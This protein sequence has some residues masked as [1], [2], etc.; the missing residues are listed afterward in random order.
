MNETNNEV[1]KSVRK[2]M[3]GEKMAS[4]DAVNN[5]EV[6]LGA[7]YVCTMNSY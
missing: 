5:S 6:A 7:N 3:N 2:I 1:R 4:E